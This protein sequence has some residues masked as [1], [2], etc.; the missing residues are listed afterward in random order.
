MDKVS[1]I[2]PIYNTA[3]YLDKCLSSIK[4]QTYTNL[5]VI[6]VNDG[7]TDD[8]LSIIQK[9]INEDERFSLINIE[10]SGVSIARNMALDIVS[11]DYI[12]FCDSDDYLEKD[13]ILLMVNLAKDNKIDVLRT[14][15]KLDGKVEKVD[16]KYKKLYEKSSIKEF[17]KY[18]VGSSLPSFL[19]VYLFDSKLLKKIRFHEDI[20]MME[21]IV[22]LYEITK[23]AKRILVS[24]IP[25]YNFRTVDT[26]ITHLKS[27]LIR[28]IESILKVNNY[29]NN[30]N[31]DKEVLDS[32][33]LHTFKL[34]A[35][36]IINSDNEDY[37]KVKDYLLNNLIYNTIKN[38]I[39]YLDLDSKEKIVFDNLDE[40]YEEF[41]NLIDNA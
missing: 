5:E 32:N 33:N 1:I 17:N 15:Y 14:T 12:T 6:L 7:S 21:D 3:K 40:D 8:S 31:I 36:Y 28:N 9:Y 41:K 27:N 39:N 20:Y 23:N 10:N 22:F 13:A 11:G 29:F 2:V 24:D 16:S 30:E 34:I 25:T 37:L 18:I 4:E 19:W 35:N 38:S 26:G